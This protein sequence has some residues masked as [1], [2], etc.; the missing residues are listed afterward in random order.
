ML[1]KSP[2]R[3]KGKTFIGSRKKNIHRIKKEV[4]EKK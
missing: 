1:P 4:V 2:L 3:E